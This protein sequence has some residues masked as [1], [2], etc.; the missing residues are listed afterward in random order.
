MSLV[1][2]ILDLAKIDNG[3]FSINKTEFDIQELLDEV[4]FIFG[5]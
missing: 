2:D 4:N 5:Y 1:E 3:T